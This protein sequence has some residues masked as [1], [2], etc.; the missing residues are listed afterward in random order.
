MNVTPRFLTA[1]GYASHADQ[2]GRWLELTVTGKIPP[3]SRT[4]DLHCGV[5]GRCRGKINASAFYVD[6]VRLQLTGTE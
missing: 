4:L 3:E 5:R 2:T 6:N 1:Q